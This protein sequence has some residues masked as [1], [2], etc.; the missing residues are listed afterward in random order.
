MIITDIT[1]QV[2]NKKRYSVFVDGEFAFGIDGVDL[3]RHGLEIGQTL[4]KE[5]YIELLKQLEYT[6]CRDTAIRILAS[7]AKSVYVMREKL[8]QKEYSPAAINAIIEL[9]L[10]KGYLDDVAYAKG[11][12]SHK[13]RINNYGRRRIEQELQQKGVSDG[14]IEAAFVDL[15]D[16]G[17]NDLEAA[18]HTLDKKLR[19]KPF[20]QD[21]RELHKLKMFMAQRGFDFET[22]DRVFAEIACCDL[23]ENVL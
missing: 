8:A 3:L 21:A 7:G 1:Q 5:R 11:F 12:I 22:I 20:P 16:D 2:K 6:K 23:A 4:E 18:R 9:L 15:G 14:D 17:D 13:S 19:N 10:E